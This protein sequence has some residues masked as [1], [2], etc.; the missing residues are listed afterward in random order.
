MTQAP[1]FLGIGG[2]V[3]RLMRPFLPGGAILAGRGGP[4]LVWDLAAGSRPLLDHAGRHG[5]PAALVVLAGVTPATG[6]D[7]AANVVVAQ[8]AMTAAQAAG[9]R[10]VLL[11]SSAAVYGRPPPE[12]P[13][14]P[15]HEADPLA[16]ASAYGAAKQAMEAA[17]LPFRDAGLEVCAL[18]I[19]NV[20]GAD[21]LL[22][23]APGPVR[24]DRFADGGGPVRSYVGPASLARILVALCDPGLTLPAAL[25]LAAP[26]PVSMQALARAAGF[27]WSWVPAPDRAVQWQLLDCRALAALVPIGD[28]EGRAE[29]LIRQWHSATGRAQETR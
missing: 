16:P 17:A 15:H 22:L 4:G 7:M 2:R 24:L 3:G 6:P 5:V 9:V 19:G 18:R 13:E 29:T 20:A 26:R 11:A 23:N 25:N 10:R 28:S 8:T 1:L 27:R 12:A 14:R 21:A